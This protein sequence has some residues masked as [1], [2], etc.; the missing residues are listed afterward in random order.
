[1][2]CRPIFNNLLFV[3]NLLICKRII[4]FSNLLYLLYYFQK[5]IV[6]MH[7]FRKSSE[8]IQ[9]YRERGN[10]MRFWMGVITDYHPIDL[11]HHPLHGLLNG[12][13]KWLYAHNAHT[14][15]KI[16]L[17]YPKKHG[18]DPQIT[19][20]RETEGV[21]GV[22]ENKSEWEKANQREREIK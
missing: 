2:V 10:D 5:K 12:F 1:M 6:P 15:R 20:Q 18:H 4:R 17:S 19:G 9:S 21:H 13:L 3:N 14:Q 16:I 11:N 22:R 7:E 8:S